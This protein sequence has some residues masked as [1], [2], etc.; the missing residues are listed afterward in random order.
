M[1]DTTKKYYT[2]KAQQFF[3]GTVTV[4]MDDLYQP[5]LDLI[6]A[7]GRIL[8]AGCG[9][10][11]DTLHFKKKGYSVF[12]FDYSEEIVRL[13]TD[14][15]GE[16]VIQMSFDDVNFD[17]EF[18]GI[19]ACASILHVPKQDISG[20]LAK[21]S[22]SLKSNGVLYTSFKYGTTEELRKGRCFSDYTESAF[23]R[24]VDSVPSLTMIKH[25]KT[26]DVRP[27]RKEEYWLNVLLIKNVLVD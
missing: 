7:Q 3:D 12:A 27:D 5:F 13:A 25:W 1:A 15:I 26:T 4:D 11:R 22:H 23:Q 24:V 19:W 16:P 2:E 14:Y 6:P 8:D 17:N 20:V 10:G 9:S 18:D 21:L